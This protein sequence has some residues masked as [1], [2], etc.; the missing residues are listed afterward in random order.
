MATE[1]IQN[2]EL[3][4]IKGKYQKYGAT[5]PYPEIEP[6]LLNSADIFDYV[7]KTGMIHPFHENQLKPA[8]YGIK[9]KGEFIYWENREKIIEGRLEDIKDIDSDGDKV[10]ILKRN[11]IAFVG[12]EPEF[13]FPDYIAARFNLKIKHIYQG[14]LLGTGPLVDPGFEGKIYIPLHN[15]TNN[16]YKIKLDKPLIWMEFTK[17]SSNKSWYKNYIPSTGRI[18]K[19]IYFDKEKLKQKRSLKDYLQ[20][21]YNGPVLSTIQDLQQQ[22]DSNLERTKELNDSASKATA[23]F[24][25]VILVSIVAICVTLFITIYQTISIHNKTIDYIQ[26]Y[27][28]IIQEA[29]SKFI[30]AETDD[31]ELKKQIIDLQEKIKNQDE[32][33]KK[34]N[35]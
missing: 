15:L 26:N 25:R 3:I 4:A 8:S 16:E 13:R 19:Y 28:K 27:D 20:E 9:M 7:E 1:L 34:I 31:L 24:N 22:I 35:K 21:A 14:L 12:L 29:H 6:S 2:Q 30:K 23:T 33:I 10:F 5:D 11:S 18:G 17:L 32:K